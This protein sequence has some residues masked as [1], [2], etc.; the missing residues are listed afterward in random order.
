MSG[1]LPSAFHSSLSDPYLL[2]FVVLSIYLSCLTDCLT[3]I[4]CIS[5]IEITE[6]QRITATEI[7]FCK[8]KNP[9]QRL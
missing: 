6:L 9:I 4:H 2:L 8:H 7:I 1:C 5:D 3:F